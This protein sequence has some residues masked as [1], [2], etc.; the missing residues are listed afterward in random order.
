MNGFVKL[1][2]VA[3]CCLAGASAVIAQEG[4]PP[5]P[6]QL[7]EQAVLTRQG[8]YKLISWQWGP[9]AR[10]LRPN[11]AFDAAVA[12][13][14]AARIKVLATL[15][16][17]AFQADTHKATVKTR[18]KENIWTNLQDFSSKADDLSKAA[19]ALEDAAKTGDKG[20][21]MKAAASVGKACGACHDNYREK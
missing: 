9:T 4:G 15:I 3:A 12:Q 6:E 20:A 21:T 18:A 10:M 13:K 14:S 17:D 16:P 5:T 7:Q 1:G 11:G 19:A 8:L 2:L